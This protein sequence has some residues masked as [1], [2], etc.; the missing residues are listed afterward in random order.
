MVGLEAGRLLRPRL[1]PGRHRSLP[2]DR[3]GL[4]DHP[5]AG[6]PRPLRRAG[7]G[8]DHRP[9]RL[10]PALDPL[11]PGPRRCPRRRRTGPR[12]RGP[13]RGRS[14]DRAAARGP[15]GRLPG[16]GRDH[17]SAGRGGDRDRDRDR[18]RLQLVPAL[19]RDPEVPDRL[20]QRQRRLLPHLP[21]AVGRARHAQRA[22]LVAAGGG[23]RRG[24]D[25]AGSGGARPEPRLAAGRRDR[26]AG[27]PPALSAPAA[28]GGD[29]RARGAPRDPGPAGAARR[30]PPRR[31]EPGSRAAPARRRRGGGAELGGVPAP[32]GGGARPRLPEAAPRAPR[33]CG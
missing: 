23:G 28:H 2:A 9:R 6:P 24:D 29:R 7:P 11:D 31:G 20:P 19:R 30:L 27:N 17:R 12:L 15:D 5:A 32:G 14:L 21:L 18:L 26:P 25:A 22:A 3:S 13:L 4:P 16:A 8:C 10:D 1:L 33:G